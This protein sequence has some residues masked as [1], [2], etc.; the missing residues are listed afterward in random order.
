VW[1]AW[2]VCAVTDAY[3]HVDSSTSRDSYLPKPFSFF[4]SGTF[5]CLEVWGRTGEPGEGIV[6]IDTGLLI[7]NANPREYLPGWAKRSE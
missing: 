5:D 1:V 7:C 3:L 6:D 2:T 4:F